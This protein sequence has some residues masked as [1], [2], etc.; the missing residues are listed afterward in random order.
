[1]PANAE[2]LRDPFVFGPRAGT[3]AQTEPT[4]VGVLWDA[5]RPLAIIG[6]ETVGIGDAIAEWRVVDIK[7][8]SITLE[9]GDRRETLYPGDPLPTE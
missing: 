9:R 6:E 3:A 8:D 2:E 5:A 7:P 1:M 4:L